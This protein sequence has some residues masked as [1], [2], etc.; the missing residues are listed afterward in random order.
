MF[1][2]VD[3]PTFTHRVTAM[4][5]TDDGHDPQSFNVTYRVLTA[6]RVADF[7]LHTNEGTTAFLCAI[8]ESCDDINDEHGAKLAWNDDVR[9]K[10]FNLPYARAA[11]SGGYFDA[12][13][14]AKK[15]N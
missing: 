6:D 15:G 13:N 8:V 11:I 10:V 2:L 14:K 1:K 12:I 5:P 3:K 7:A 4:V 9:D